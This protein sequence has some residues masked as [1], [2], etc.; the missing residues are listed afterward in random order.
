MSGITWIML[1]MKIPRHLFNL[2]I[3]HS[4]LRVACRHLITLA[5][6]VSSSDMAMAASFDCNKAVSTID[7]RICASPQLQK[8]DEHMGELYEQRAVGAEADAWRTDQ[9]AWLR[10]R[11][12]CDDAGCLQRVY[13]ERLTVLEIGDGPFHWQGR[14]WR[15]DASG[16]YSAVAE[17]RDLTTKGLHF[18]LD[19]SAGANQGELEGTARF[20][21]DGVAKYVR[22][23]SSQRCEL[24]FRRRVNRIEIE[25]SGDQFACGAGMGV[26]YDGT[27]VL[28]ESDPNGAPDLVALGVVKTEAQNLAMRKLLGSDYDALAST[29]DGVSDNSAE[30]NVPGMTVVDTFVEGLACDMKAVVAYDTSGR[31]WVGLWSPNA[32]AGLP[33][34]ASGVVEL[35]YYTNSP[36]D[37]RR[38][39]AAIESRRNHVCPSEREVMRM[40]P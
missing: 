36:T 16:H 12:S 1:Y 40:M 37:K 15:V 19:A 25:Q 17:I 31:V 30:F 4:L 2:L 27:Y 13:L 10:M 26:S 34:L 24:T 3:M 39:P 35:R 11:D 33:K 18:H 20:D 21:A 23:D 5:V 9:R 14:W 6:I 38:L 29:A 32:K 7:R 28:A 22:V 8:L